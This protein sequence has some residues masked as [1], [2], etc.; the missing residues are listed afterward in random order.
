[1]N[2]W[3]EY[4]SSASEV[5]YNVAHIS[6]MQELNTN[7]VL[8]YVN[9]CIEIANNDLSILDSKYHKLVIRTLQWMDVAKCGSEKQR[10]LHSS[11]CLGR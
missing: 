9:R 7:K 8:E 6:S 5:K 4:L 2:K 3:L 1:M 11:L 10:E